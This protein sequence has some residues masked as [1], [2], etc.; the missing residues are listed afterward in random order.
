MR[1]MA[2]SLTKDAIL[3]Q[4]KTVTRRQGWANLQSGM[5]IQPIEKG[6][7]LKKG[8][9]QKL[10]GGPIRVRNVRM[11]PIEAITKEDV[12]AEGFGGFTPEQFISIYCKA[13]KVK[14]Y[15]KC[16]RIEFEYV[17]FENPKS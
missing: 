15:D 7:G 8:E 10:L 9:K 14:P 3:S 11:E 16:V 1:R 12:I 17:P 13:N 4:R 5:L 6:M 2:F